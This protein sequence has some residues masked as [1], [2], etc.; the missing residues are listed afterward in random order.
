VQARLAVVETHVEYLREAVDQ[1][2]ATQLEIRDQQLAANAAEKARQAMVV[3]IASVTGTGFGLVG[4]AIGWLISHGK[5]P[6]GTLALFLLLGPPPALAQRVP[7]P[8]EPTA[9]RWVL[10]VRACPPHGRCK[11]RRAYQA[12]QAGCETVQHRLLDRVPLMQPRIRLTVSANCLVERD[13][14]S[15]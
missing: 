8:G 2:R 9:A 12:S 6:V 5:L 3:K 1:I 15:A 7:Q 10:L 11:E 4:S 13:D 14:A